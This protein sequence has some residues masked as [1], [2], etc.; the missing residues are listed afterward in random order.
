MMVFLYLC[1]EFEV[2]DLFLRGILKGGLLFESKWNIICNVERNC[3]VWKRC[4]V[5]F[6]LLN[7]VYEDLLNIGL[8]IFFELK[9][10]IVIEEDS[11]VYLECDSFRE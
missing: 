6:I 2:V 11:C 10:D 4:L 1:W 3:D 8:L 5:F 7:F 9:I